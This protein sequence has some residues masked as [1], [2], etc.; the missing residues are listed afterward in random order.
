MKN[1]PYVGRGGSYPDTGRKPIGAVKRVKTSLGIEPELLAKL[2]TLVAQGQGTRSD[3]VNRL[4]TNCT[5]QKMDTNWIKVGLKF[6]GKVVVEVIETEKKVRVETE[7]GF[8]PVKQFWGF[9]ELQE[10]RKNG[11]C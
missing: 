5:E 1:T 10:L 4:L 9:H 7:D 11:Y 8:I 6:L 2:D 3:I